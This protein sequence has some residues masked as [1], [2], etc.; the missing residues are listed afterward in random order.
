MFD[1]AAARETML[2]CQ[3]RTNDVTDHDIQAA[4]KAVPRECFVPKSKIALA[5]SDVHIDLGDGRFMLRPRDFAKMLDAADIGGT[6]VVLNIG[7]GRGYSVAVLSQLAETVVALEQTGEIVT[8][9]TELLD[10]CGTNNAAVVRGDF[11]A[12]A[13]EHGP[14][15]VIFVGGSVA[16]VPQ[17]WQDQLANNGRLIVAVNDGPVSRVKVYKKT[18]DKIGE[19]TV[20]DANIPDL[21]GFEH[22]HIFAL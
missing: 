5:Y 19:R 14:F 22:K 9:A 15:D 8:R 2:D 6:D 11:R 21:P 13:P 16:S 12:G 17:T 1:F 20:F 18:N 4:F 10:R 7:C 3:I